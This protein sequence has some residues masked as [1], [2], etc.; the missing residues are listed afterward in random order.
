M[1]I[2]AGRKRGAGTIGKK[3]FALFGIGQNGADAGGAQFRKGLSPGALKAHT[4]AGGNS[5]EQL[6]VF[7]VAQSVL[8]RLGGA[9]GG[10]R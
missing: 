10:R 9:A 1:L 3:D 2:A 7:A 5:E 4:L 6:E 8:Q